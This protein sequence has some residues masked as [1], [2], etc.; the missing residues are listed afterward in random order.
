LELELQQVRWAHADAISEVLDLVRSDQ[1]L[2]HVD[3]Y[4]QGLWDLYATL[5]E[6]FG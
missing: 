3:Q 1:P 6:V 4:Q 2:G 5:K